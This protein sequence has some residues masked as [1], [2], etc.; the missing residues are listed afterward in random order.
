MSCGQVFGRLRYLRKHQVTHRADKKFLC[1]DCGKAFKTKAYLAAHRQTHETKL[2]R[3]SQCDFA[4]SISVLIHSHRQVHSDDSVI[5]DV[6]GA[7][8]MD[9]ATLRKHKRVHDEARPFPCAYPGCTWRFKTEVMGRAHFRGHT[10]SGRFICS[11]CNYVFRHKHHLQ[12][13]L[14]KVHCMD[15]ATVYRTTSSKRSSM[16]VQ[17]LGAAEVCEGKE[18]VQ[19]VQEEEQPLTDT[20]NLIVN[21]GLSSEQLQSVLESGQFVIASDESDGAVNYEVANITMNVTYDTLVEGEEM[22]SESQT[23]LIP[24]NAECSQI[25][26]Q[27][28]CETVPTSSARVE[29]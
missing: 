1:A 22:V 15:E 25:I 13:H 9:R 20:V 26:F 5:C 27:Q 23:I 17:H 24:H 8:Y 12:R 11:L 3:C 6:C 7:A 19:V 28:E 10:T 29:T 2:Y 16:Q 4:S 14:G 21:S 18:L